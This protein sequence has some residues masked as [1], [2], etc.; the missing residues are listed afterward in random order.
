MRCDDS[1][2]KMIKSNKCPCALRPWFIVLTSSLPDELNG[3]GVTCE[4]AETTVAPQ[5]ELAAAAAAAA[6]VGR[7]RMLS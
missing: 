2:E 1:L 6:R 7:Q 5:C 3:L 4:E